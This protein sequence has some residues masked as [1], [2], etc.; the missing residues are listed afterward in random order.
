MTY[1]IDQDALTMGDLIA[2]SNAGNNL[3][4]QIE[5]LRKCVVVENGGRIE[6]L[7]AR[8][9]RAIVNV[10]KEVMTGSGN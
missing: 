2:L 1:T 10:I 7:P 8:H 5:I 6:D 9:Y 3:A 4:A